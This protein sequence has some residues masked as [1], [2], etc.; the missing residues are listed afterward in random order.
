MAKKYVSRCRVMRNGKRVK[1]LKN[2]KMGEAVYR[3][4]VQTFDGQGTVDVPRKPSFTFDYALPSTDATL[5]WSDVSD[6][7]WVVELDGGKRA[8]FSGV[9][10]IKRGEVTMDMEKEVVF[11]IEFSAETETIQ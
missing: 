6:E 11:T 4:P 3:A 5:D 1:N 2:F 10:C 7:T 8:I 9:D